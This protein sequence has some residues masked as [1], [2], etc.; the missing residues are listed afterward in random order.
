MTASYYF[1]DGYWNGNVWMSHQWF[2]WKALLDH[3][4]GDFAFEVAKRALDIW[5]D[6]TDFSYNTYECFGIKTKRGGWFHNFG[7]LSAPVC[8]WAHA[9]YKPGTV[10]TGF[11]VWTDSQSADENGAE[12]S[13]RYYG[14]NERYTVLVTLGEGDGFSATLDGVPVPCRMRTR[15]TA[16]I[17]L[18][19][20]VKGSCLKIAKQ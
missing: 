6:E 20:S 9:Y 10:T 15:G 7:G 2:I 18:D 12:I 3:G 8:I 13:F 1:D 17:T 4:E 11:E 14:D 19:G 5:K 16:E